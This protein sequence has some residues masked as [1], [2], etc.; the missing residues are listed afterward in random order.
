MLV[1]H[2]GARP[3]VHE[4]AYVAPSAIVVGAV[5]IA[6]GSRV[7]HGAVL[8]AEDGS[9]RVGRHVVIMENAVVRGRADHPV[10]IGDHVMVGPH[11]HVNGT[12]VADEV[13]VATG[14]ALFP[15]A[16]VGKGSEVRINAVVHVNTHVPP[17]S[18][19]PIGWV[20]VGRPAR[21]LP[22]EQHEEIWS[23]QRELDFLGTV[24]GA[25]P[26][27]SMRK[28]MQG[29]SEYYGSHASDVVL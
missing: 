1:E 22:P 9:V 4:T 11:T 2:R 10:V 27:T 7:L 15:G 24:Y 18:V 13:F 29:Q 21:I 26:D 8:S 23:I 28:L 3:T 14:A 6:A 5:D 16:T 12:H 25:G 19:V 20:A 17:G